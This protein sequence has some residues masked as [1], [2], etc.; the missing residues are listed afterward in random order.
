MNNCKIQN[1]Q[2]LPKSKNQSDFYSNK[3]F[4]LLLH[5]TRVPPHLGIIVN[6]VGYSLT[7][8][9]PKVNWG[10]S[11]IMRLVS[12][13][14]VK[15]ILFELNLTGMKKWTFQELNDIA[16]KHTLTHSS[17]DAKEITC[18]FPLKMFCSD[19]YSQNYQSV[20]F[21]FDLVPKLYDI[22]AIKN[23][24]Q[25]NLENDLIDGVFCLPRYSMKDVLNHIEQQTFKIG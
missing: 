15:S 10:L 18:L 25:A 13:K 1:I 3:V 20:H 12:V 6:G 19:V 7:I 16:V 24:Y 2:T 4:L 11:D 8:Y 23:V 14:K 21:V 22:A 5:A 17:V 9:G